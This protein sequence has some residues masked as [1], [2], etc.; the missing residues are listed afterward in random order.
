MMRLLTDTNI[1]IYR[2]DS[3]VIPSNLQS[4]LKS[5]NELAVEILVHPLLVREIERDK[6]EERKAIKSFPALGEAE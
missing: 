2:E 5:L 6:N 4:L 3:R 1:F